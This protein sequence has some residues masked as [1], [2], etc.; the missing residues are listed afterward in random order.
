MRAVGGAEDGRLEDGSGGTGIPED[1]GRVERGC[2]KLTAERG[3]EETGC[4]AE[5]VR[6]KDTHGVSRWH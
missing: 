2:Q 1:E 4:A 6:G 5:S 3:R